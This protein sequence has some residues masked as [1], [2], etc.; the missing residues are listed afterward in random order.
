MVV[1][2]GMDTTCRRS[3]SRRR[4][5]TAIVVGWVVNPVGV[6]MARSP[7]FYWVD[8]RRISRA[9]TLGRGLYVLGDIQF[10]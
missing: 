9:R 2:A 4:C 5:D 10:R 8:G 3:L 7:P 1:P 6:S